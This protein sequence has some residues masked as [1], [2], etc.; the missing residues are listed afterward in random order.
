MEVFVIALLSAAVLVLGL[1]GLG[2]SLLYVQVRDKYVNL[3][4]NNLGFFSEHIDS[5]ARIFEQRTGLSNYV[6]AL[7][8]SADTVNAAELFPQ[9]EDY[10]QYCLEETRYIFERATGRRC[11]TSIKLIEIDG[12]TNLKITTFARDRNSAKKRAQTDEKLPSIAA[13]DHSP[14]ARI[15]ADRSGEMSYCEND[16]RALFEKGEYKNSNDRW[17]E[18]YNATCVVPIAHKASGA[19]SAG[20][21][22]TDILGFLCV[23]SLDGRFD[24][25]FSVSI[26]KMVAVSLFYTFETMAQF[27]EL[28]GA[29]I[30]M[31]E[32]KSKEA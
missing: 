4:N 1:L 2:I 3:K 6:Y 10:I 30:E 22:G 12:D 14:F 7:E 16:L 31:Q 29:T 25:A 20:S 18:F 24:R 27:K 17:R 19:M 32:S 5:L 23:D 8:N 9:I 11:A 26:L 21:A 13:Y 28:Y 15:V